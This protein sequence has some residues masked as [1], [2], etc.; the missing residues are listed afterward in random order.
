VTVPDYPP[1][2]IVIQVD[3]DDEPKVIEDGGF[4]PYLLETILT[5]AAIPYQTVWELNPSEATEEES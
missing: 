4:A 1:G 2:R 5:R 3:L